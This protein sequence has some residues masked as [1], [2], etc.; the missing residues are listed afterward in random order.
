[1]SHICHRVLSHCRSSH[2]LAKLLTCHQ[3]PCSGQI[4]PRAMSSQTQYQFQTL[5]VS[6]VKDYVSQV[7]LNRPEKRNAMNQ[8]FWGEMVEC[9]NQLSADPECR[10]VVLTGAGPVF[11]A[12]LDLSDLNS[13][14]PR[15]DD[16]ARNAMVIR[17]HVKQMQESFNVI[18][19]CPKPV[20]AAI[21]GPCVG[22]GVDMV[23]ACDIRYCTRDA[24]FQI[25][26]VD[27][28]I[29]ADLGTLQRFPKVVGNDSLVRELA[30]TA[31]KLMADEAKQCGLVSLLF[32]SKESLLAGALETATIIASKSPVAVQGSKVAM[33]FARDNSVQNSLEQVAMWNQGM[34]L[35]EDVIKAVT[36]QMQKET[37]VFS[38]L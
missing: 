13:V 16:I 33:V 38:K 4:V 15:E 14:V 8:I 18:E 23:T 35:S 37:P 11:T 36:G 9:F 2:K 20:I 5:K 30:F 7:E 31:R 6:Q 17:R 10:V 29:A 3:F 25:K 27:I 26:E 1:M 24:W 22:G 12:G 28:G 34:L 21:H 32:P 19:K